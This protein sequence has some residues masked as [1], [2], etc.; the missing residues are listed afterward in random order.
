MFLNTY[1]PYTNNH[2][3]TTA[4]NSNG[5]KNSKKN[6]LSNLDTNRH[7]QVNNNNNNNKDEGE[8]EE[9]EDEDSVI[10]ENELNNRSS[11]YTT[12]S[13]SHTTRKKRLRS[14]NKVIDEWLADEVGDD[15]YADLEDF[16]C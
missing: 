15:V 7:L 1:H 5:N 12:K 16:V 8:Q 14:R 6:K 4:S 9:E 10:E 11:H 2:I 3:N 13:L